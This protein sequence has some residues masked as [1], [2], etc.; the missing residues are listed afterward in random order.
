MPWLAVGAIAPLPYLSPS[1]ATTS[2]TYFLLYLLIYLALSLKILTLAYYK[3][4]SV[5]KIYFSGSIVFT[6]GLIFE[7]KDLVL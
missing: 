2:S 6:K 5:P 7:A 3:T 1:S 4:S